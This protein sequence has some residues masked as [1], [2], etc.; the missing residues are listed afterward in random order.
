MTGRK[1][2]AVLL[3]GRLD[4]SRRAGSRS[5]NRYRVDFAQWTIEQGHADEDIHLFQDLADP[6]R[7]YA[8]WRCGTERSVEEWTRQMRYKEFVMR[9]RAF[10]AQCTPAIAQP[11]RSVT[12][13]IIERPKQP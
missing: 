12:R 2:R 9:M 13:A 8:L 7:F 4:A 10:C 5:S 1:G 6:L 11:V 3:R